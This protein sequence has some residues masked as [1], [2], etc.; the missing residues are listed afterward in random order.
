MLT[1][2]SYLERT[3]QGVLGFGSHLCLLTCAR[4][5][6]WTLQNQT[7]N[8]TKVSFVLRVISSRNSAFYYLADYFCAGKKR[9]HERSAKGLERV[10]KLE[11]RDW[12]ETWTIFFL[13]THLMACTVHA[14]RETIWRK[15]KKHEIQWNI[16]LIRLNDGPRDWQNVFAIKRGFPYIE[17]L[18]HM[19]YYYWGKQ[20]RSLYR[21]IRLMYKG[22]G[23]R[24]T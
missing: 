10:W 7:A 4:W 14:P 6:D 24:F 16:H 2:T 11:V 8:Q 22:S 21:W 15:T 20:N 9:T 23:E 1:F 13:V 18:P 5:G 19:F 3:I 12:Q 17:V